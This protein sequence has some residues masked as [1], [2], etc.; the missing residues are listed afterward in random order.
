MADSRC[1]QVLLFVRAW[2][3]LYWLRQP[4]HNLSLS[5]TAAA[6][7]EA[8]ERVS[9]DVCVMVKMFLCF[10]PIALSKMIP[11]IIGL[12]ENRAVTASGDYVR[13]ISGFAIGVDIY[14]L[15]KSGLI[16]ISDV[17]Q[18]LVV[19]RKDRRLVM[20]VAL[21]AGIAE[22][23]GCVLL[24][25][26]N[27][28]GAIIASL[29]NVNDDVVSVVQTTLGLLSGNAIIFG[30]TFVH[31][32]IMTQKRE[33]M[34]ILVTA[35]LDLAIQSGIN[36]S[37]ADVAQGAIPPTVIPII[38]LYT[39]SI[40][41]LLV[42]LIWYY[43]RVQ[44]KISEDR[45]DGTTIVLKEAVGIFF[46]LASLEFARSLTIPLARMFLCR[47]LSSENAAVQTAIFSLVY[48]AASLFTSPLRRL[49]DVYLAFR[50]P[51]DGLTTR[52]AFYF[53][54]FC[55]ALTSAI[56]AILCGVPGLCATCFH[57]IF[58]IDWR[59]AH[60]CTTPMSVC[61]ARPFLITINSHVLYSLMNYRRTC[62]I[63]LFSVLQL[64]AMPVADYILKCMNVTGATLGFSL[65]VTFE[66]VG[67]VLLIGIALLYKYEKTKN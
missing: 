29:F 37:F 65:F 46:P 12:T 6:V 24:A 44:Q 41:R 14:M 7:L 17:A 54:T 38:A 53:T 26:T 51:G 52:R 10:A 34:V 35:M 31:F 62:V 20:I 47:G 32:G 5:E 19:S 22:I 16:A 49:K 4:T 23:F 39:G 18:V 40:V 8:M 50:H 15:F 1:R 55:F 27:A 36:L 63:L 45:D 9:T 59:L 56:F 42:T 58:H 67:T 61:I 21:I 3:Q 66:G 30:L 33:T 13:Q 64:A 28:G 11:S 57:A 2:F 25:T 48:P 60:S 43:T